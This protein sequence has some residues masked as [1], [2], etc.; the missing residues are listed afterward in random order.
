MGGFSL[1]PSGLALDPGRF[2]LLPELLRMLL[3]ALS[4]RVDLREDSTF[5][6]YLTRI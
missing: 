2:A 5:V 3:T 4:Q 6:A 1:F